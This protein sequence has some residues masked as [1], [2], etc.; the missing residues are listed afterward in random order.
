MFGLSPAALK[1]LGF[2]FQVELAPQ[3]KRDVRTLMYKRVEAGW[4]AGWVGGWVGGVTGF[5]RQTESSSSHTLDRYLT[6][7]K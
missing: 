5:K 3:R 1:V 7:T 6:T 4:V 2:F